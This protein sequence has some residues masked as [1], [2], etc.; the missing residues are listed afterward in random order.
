MQANYLIILIIGA[1]GGAASGILGIG[2][3]VVLVPLLVTIL[4]MAQHNAQGT[5]L[6][7]LC[8]P[9]GLAAAIQYHQKGF[10]DWRMAVLLF[11]GFLAGGYLGGH[12]AVGL[13]QRVLQ[14]MFGVVLVALGAR[15]LFLR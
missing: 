15:M 7:M 10:V 6:A 13:T 8:L 4:G 5:T 2:G 14:K 9:A 3:G 12:F 11:V 1:T